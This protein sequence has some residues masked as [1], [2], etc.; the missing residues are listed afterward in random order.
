MGRPLVTRPWNSVG[1]AHTCFKFKPEG[2]LAVAFHRAS[3]V[4]QGLG[5]EVRVQRRPLRN[6]VLFEVAVL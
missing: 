6:P 1:Q 5:K 4:P 3:N 2:P